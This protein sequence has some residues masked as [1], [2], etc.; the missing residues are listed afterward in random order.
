DVCFELILQWFRQNKVLKETKL[1]KVQHAGGVVNRARNSVAAPCQ[2]AR[3]M[4]SWRRQRR[5]NFLATH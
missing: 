1:I 5:D 4:L 3:D 2:Y